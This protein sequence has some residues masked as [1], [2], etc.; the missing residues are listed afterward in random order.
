MYGGCRHEGLKTLRGYVLIVNLV[1]GNRFFIGSQGNNSYISNILISHIPR[2]LALAWVAVSGRSSIRL[3]VSQTGGCGRCCSTHSG[4]ARRRR[5]SGALL[6]HRIYVLWPV[7]CWPMPCWP[8]AWC[9]KHSTF[10]PEQQITTENGTMAA[11]YA[12][13]VLVYWLCLELG[14]PFRGCGEA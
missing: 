7:A 12:F 2:K 1:A 13:L 3:I 8:A 6:C 11:D 10:D 4:R 14:N 9:D 5:R